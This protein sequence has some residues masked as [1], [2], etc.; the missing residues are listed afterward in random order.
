MTYKLDGRRF[1]QHLRYCFQIQA[2]QAQGCWLVIVAHGRKL[3]PDVA[4][5]LL[6][7]GGSRIEGEQAEHWL[8]P[9]LF[10][11]QA[12]ETLLEQ[13]C[14]AAEDEREYLAVLLETRQL[15]TFRAVVLPS[16]FP[17][18]WIVALQAPTSSGI[19]VPVR[20]PKPE[21]HDQI[22]PAFAR[23]TRAQA[24][25]TFLQQAY[26]AAV[27]PSEERLAE[28]VPEKRTKA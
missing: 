23:K 19:W 10:S 8:F 15:A 3:A 24:Y 13:A 20:L 22:H 21:Q 25:A 12:L 5:R 7:Q 14:R 27:S 2:D 1:L 9:Q 6:A 11:Q 18:Q 16:A 28:P 17:H 26:A 4:D